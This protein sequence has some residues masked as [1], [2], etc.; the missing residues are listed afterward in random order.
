MLRYWQGDWDSF[1]N[2]WA[3]LPNYIGMNL[4]LDAGYKSWKAIQFST[5]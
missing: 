2:Y 1:G 5:L 3:S 4:K